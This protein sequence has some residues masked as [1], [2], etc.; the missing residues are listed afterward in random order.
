MIRF[1]D[2]HDEQEAAI[3]KEFIALVT[4]M[5]QDLPED[6]N[7]AM[8][9]IRQKSAGLIGPRMETYAASAKHFAREAGFEFDAF[10][11]LAELH[12]DGEAMRSL[13]VQRQTEAS[14]RGITAGIPLRDTIGLTVPQV[15]ALIT[16]ERA[17]REANDEITKNEGLPERR[18]RA[19]VSR[20]SAQAV[21]ARADVVAQTEATRAMSQGIEAAAAQSGQEIIRG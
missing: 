5:R 9:V 16:Y 15:Q 11:G 13:F 3:R 20:R 12:G 7:D 17:L 6:L 4:R 21:S 8:E 18:I 14:W 10:A 1:A 19:M 2:I